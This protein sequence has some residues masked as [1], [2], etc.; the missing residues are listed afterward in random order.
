MNGKLLSLMMTTLMTASALAGCAGGD[1]V[2][3]DD[4]DGGYTYASDVDNHRMLM[5]DVC[6]IKDLSGAYDWDAVAEIYENG[7]YAGPFTPPELRSKHAAG[8]LDPDAL[9]FREGMTEWLPLSEVAA[10]IRIKLG[11]A[12]AGPADGIHTSFD[13]VHTSVGGA[14][15][16]LE[17][18]QQ[19]VA[20]QVCTRRAE[21]LPAPPWF[22]LLY[23]SPSPRDS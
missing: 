7:E 6:D 19:A 12:P 16:D 4:A 14:E 5:G 21:A 1:D 22:C 17:Q 18:L 23:T 11:G 8:S 10:E 9:F 20:M 3:L 2:D 13:G 15:E